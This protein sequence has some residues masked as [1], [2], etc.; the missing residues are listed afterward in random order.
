[1]LSVCV[2]FKA[3]HGMEIVEKD[4]RLSPGRAD[5]AARR[6]EVRLKLAN[7]TESRIRDLQKMLRS[8]GRVTPALKRAGTSA[9]D[10]SNEK[11]Q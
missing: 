11:I 2:W 3:D 8:T 10:F 1:M 6:I 9:R 5:L 7:M 4:I